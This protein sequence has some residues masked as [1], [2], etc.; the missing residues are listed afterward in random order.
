MGL[1]GRGS[2]RGGELCLGDRNFGGGG[3]GGKD[4]GINSLVERFLFL[5]IHGRGQSMDLL[6]MYARFARLNSSG[7]MVFPP[8]ESFCRHLVICLLLGFSKS[9]PCLAD[10]EGRPPRFEKKAEKESSRARRQVPPHASGT[11]G[12]NL[13]NRPTIKLRRENDEVKICGTKQE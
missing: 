8:R 6:M 11:E 12:S 10:S 3:G 13:N 2:V 7:F 4:G 5:C 9:F 1:C